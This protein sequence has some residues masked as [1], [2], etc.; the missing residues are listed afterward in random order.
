M[1]HSDR[2]PELWHRTSE[3]ARFCHGCGLPITPAIEYAEYKQVT[4]LFV[5]AKTLGFAALSGGNAMTADVLNLLAPRGGQ[6]APAGYWA[7]A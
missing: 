2:V 6:I 5:D 3:D 4:V 1:D 7:D